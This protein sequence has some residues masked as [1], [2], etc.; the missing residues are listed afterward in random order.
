MRA[1]LLFLAVLMAPAV[2][3]DFSGRVLKVQDGD[4]L[5]VLV[6]RQQVRVRLESIDAPELGQAFGKRSRR[7]LADICA[8]KIASVVRTG[9]DRYGRTLGWVTCAG[10]EANSAQVR[11]GMAWVFARYIGASSPLYEL[12]AYARLREIGLWADARPVAPW[13]W[14]TANRKSK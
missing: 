12:E 13:E 3:A 6:N 11:R 10:V 1:L 7:S 4:R 14:R 9:K 5:T 2:A 8:A